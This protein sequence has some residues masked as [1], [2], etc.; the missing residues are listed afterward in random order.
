MTAL[1]CIMWA[2]I[3]AVAA[4]GITTAR[5]C[6]TIARLRAE[7]RQE[8]GYWQAET[9][10]ARALA[11]QTARDAATRATAWKEGRDDVIAIMPLIVLAR[12]GASPSLVDDD[13]QTQAS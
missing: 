3:A 1:F 10:R 2:A 4:W 5:S 8:I 11:A 12:E 13:D 6:A 9:A 7:M